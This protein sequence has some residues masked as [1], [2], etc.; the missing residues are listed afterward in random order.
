[1]S[2]LVNKWRSSPR[3]RASVR[4]SRSVLA[5]DERAWPSRTRRTQARLSAVVKALNAMAQAIAIRRRCRYR[6][7]KGGD[8]TSMLSATR[9][10]RWS[11]LAT[12]LKQ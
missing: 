9:K 12:A 4:R 8:H 6:I 10:R 2:Q 7:V 11:K 5:A 1:M 3:F